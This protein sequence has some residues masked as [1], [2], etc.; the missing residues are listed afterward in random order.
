MKIEIDLNDIL[1]DHDGVPEESLNEAIRRQVVENLTKR[2]QDGIGRRLDEE[3][4]RRISEV[5]QSEVASRAPAFVETLFDAPYRPVDRF[6]HPGHPTTFR[7]E[8]LKSI[9][10]Q[11]TYKPETYNDRKNA[12]T[13]AVDDTVRAKLAEFQKEWTR[14]VDSQFVNTALQHAT[15]QLRK[16]MGVA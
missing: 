1:R 5:V 12:F 14:R 16:R 9:H 3:I 6:G 11:M 4:S 7:A 2:M 15:E 8:L 10:E 13:K